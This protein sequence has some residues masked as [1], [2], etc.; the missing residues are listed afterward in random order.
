MAIKAPP[1]HRLRGFP[2]P[3]GEG[4]D[5][6]C[7]LLEDGARRPPSYYGLPRQS[8]EFFVLHSSLNYTPYS[9]GLFR[10][11]SRTGA[12][13]PRPPSP[14]RHA[15]CNIVGQGSPRPVLPTLTV[16]LGGVLEN[17]ARRPSS[18][19]DMPCLNSPPRSPAAQHCYYQQLSSLQAPLPLQYLALKQKYFMKNLSKCLEVSIKVYT[20]A[21][22][23]KK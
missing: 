22:A 21:L 4:S 7:F 14:N 19:Y 8:C 2:L 16:M 1:P 11:Y 6:S 9:L 13:V 17:G 18:Y 23:F 15:W 12:S 10:H 5:Y 3:V 20:F